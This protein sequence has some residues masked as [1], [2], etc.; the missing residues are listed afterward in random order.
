[1]KR[2]AGKVLAVLLL[3]LLFLPAAAP[4]AGQGTVKKTIGEW[5]TIGG[6]Y[7]F[8]I[9][10]LRGEVPAFWN[11]LDPAYQGWLMGGMVGPPPPPTDAFKVKNDVLYT[12]RFGI[13]LH[14][15]ATRNVTVTARLLMYKSFGSQD[16]SAVSGLS[17]SAGLQPF[18]AD[19]V[20]VFDGTA[21]HIPGEGKLSVDVAYATWKNLFGR[22]IWFSVGR[23]PS[24]GGIP[25]H[26]RQ[27]TRKPGNAGIPAILVDYAFDGMTLGW[28]PDIEALPGA[29]AKICYG[30]G[31]E[32]GITST[33]GNGLR[34]TDMIGVS[35]VPYDTDPLYLN[36]QWNRGMNIFDFPVINSNTVFG[37]TRPSTDLGDIDWFGL[38]LLS[39]LKNIG[40][41]RLHLFGSGGL[42]ITHPNDNLSNGM[43]GLLY[44][45]SLEQ[46]DD[47]TGWAAYVGA[48]YDVNK[49]RTKIGV[50]Y[51]HGSEDW[52]TFAPAA[53]DIWT[54]KLG[55]RGNVYEVYL[56]QEFSLE[57]ISSYTSKTFFRIGYQYYDFDYTGSN[58]WVGSPVKIADLAN[59]PANAQM[60]IPMKN[61]QDL[62][63]MLE[64]HF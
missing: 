16:D 9:D 26:L 55:T 10:S 39:N 14:A 20:G 59:S 23:R 8:R 27:N 4:A 17:T 60:L 56:I 62:Y 51:N 34:D 52:I 25:S 2:C 36:V 35:L 3:V 42:S 21:G 49:E 7:R 61:A 22:P 1:M 50:E 29:Y 37:S 45:P 13:D 57:P 18:F 24:T 64:V 28:A 38:T 54:S 11:F 19:R 33:T 40:P 43:A 63:G 6:D 48:R 47:K 5:L 15:K 30:R 44:S 46:K 53:D 31:F 32:N 12:N 58:N 41:G